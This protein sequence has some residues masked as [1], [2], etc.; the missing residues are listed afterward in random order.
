MA[1][2]QD[3]N[4]G[5]GNMVMGAGMMGNSFA[6]MAGKPKE[7]EGFTTS[8]TATGPN[9]PMSDAS[10]RFAPQNGIG[11]LINPADNPQN[12]V[13]QNT[14]GLFNQRYPYVN[15]YGPKYG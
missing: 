11:N 9:T 10:M 14:Y 2:K 7:S 4:T 3:Q 1:G 5:L 6:T 13:P 15:M 12:F 8:G